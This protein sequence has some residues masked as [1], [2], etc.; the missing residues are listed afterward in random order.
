MYEYSGQGVMLLHF[1]EIL[2]GKLHKNGG[3]GPL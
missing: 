3:G 2:F 1:L